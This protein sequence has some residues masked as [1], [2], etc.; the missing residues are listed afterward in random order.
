MS[1]KL[2]FA[3]DLV[4]EHCVHINVYTEDW[5]QDKLVHV[6]LIFSTKIVFQLF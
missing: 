3:K 1:L 5:V 6:H 4:I 2:S